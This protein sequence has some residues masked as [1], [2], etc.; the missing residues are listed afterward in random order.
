LSAKFFRHGRE[1]FQDVTISDISLKRLVT[2]CTVF[3]CSFVS[4]PAFVNCALPSVN[5][6]VRTSK[7]GVENLRA[8]RGPREHLIWPASEFSL[9]KFEYNIVSKVLDV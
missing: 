1:T 8:K 2:D 3:Q 5:L 9:P 6:L 4:L 7:S